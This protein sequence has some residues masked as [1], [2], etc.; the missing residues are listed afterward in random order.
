MLYIE[1]DTFVMQSNIRPFRAGG[2]VYTNNPLF[3]I[4]GLYSEMAL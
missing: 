2:V 4:E 3:Y 1:D